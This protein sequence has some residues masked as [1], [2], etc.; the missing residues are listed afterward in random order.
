MG[1]SSI[2]SPPWARSPIDQGE[3]HAGGLRPQ[4]GRRALDVSGWSQIVELSTKA[5]PDEA[6]QVAAEARAFLLSL[7]VDLTGEAADEDQDRARV[8]HEREADRLTEEGATT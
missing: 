1:S 6:F 5:K 3:G 8:L 4:A 7:G 2:R